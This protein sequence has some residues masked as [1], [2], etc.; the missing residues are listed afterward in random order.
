MWG[1]D[2]ADRSASG[3]TID[4][5]SCELPNIQP[6]VLTL[7]PS[8]SENNIT[9]RKMLLGRQKPTTNHTTI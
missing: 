3:L 7:Q 1:N 5:I 9:G 4:E 6:T 2:L 8:R